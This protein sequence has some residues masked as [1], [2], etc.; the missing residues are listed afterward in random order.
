MRRWTPFAPSRLTPHRKVR[1]GSLR[2]SGRLR[3]LQMGKNLKLKEETTWENGGCHT[4]KTSCEWLER[5]FRQ[6][7]HFHRYLAPVVLGGIRFC[8]KQR[9]MSWVL[10]SAAG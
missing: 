4:V 5:L 8:R 2:H 9:E 3:R 1:A 7:S 6:R 10:S